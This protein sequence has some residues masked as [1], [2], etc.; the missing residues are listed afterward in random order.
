M[1]PMPPTDGSATD[2]SG[3][4]VARFFFM[5]LQKTAGTSLVIRLGHQF[6]PEQIYPDES[7]GNQLTVMP[8]FAIDVLQERWPVRRE[9]VRVVTG[10]FPLCTAELLGDPFTTLTVLRE[11]V[12]RTLSYLRHHRKMI[13]ESR[14]LPLEEVYDDPMR[15][16]GLIHNHMVKMLALTPEEMTSGEMTGAMT[17]VDFTPEHLERAKAALRTVDAVGLQERFDDFVAELESR[18][19]WDLGPEM[20][21]NQTDQVEVD[22]ALRARIVEDNALDIALYDFARELVAERAAQ[23]A[24]VSEP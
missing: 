15:F 12:E 3:A 7:D 17:T 6:T 18:F 1:P 19:G 5:H 22:D 11:P 4:D 21:A 14:E 9:Q 23:A 2:S 10:H 24:Q 8:Q 20:F 13:K 16:P